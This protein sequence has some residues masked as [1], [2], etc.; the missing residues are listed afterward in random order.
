MPLAVTELEAHRALGV[1]GGARRNGGE[2]L[3][4]THYPRLREVAAT[5]PLVMVHSRGRWR[6]VTLRE[7]ARP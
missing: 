2:R 5:M 4:T 1:R 6:D 3:V 7:L